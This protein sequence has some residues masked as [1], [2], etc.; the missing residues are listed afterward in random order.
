MSGGT[1]PVSPGG[2]GEPDPSW[3]DQEA[4]APP[5]GPPE[6]GAA[7][8]SPAPVNDPFAPAAPAPQQPQPSVPPVP[9]VQQI[10]PVRPIQPVQ[11]P[12]HPPPTQPGQPPQQPPQPPQQ[13]SW[14]QPAAPPPYGG[15][16]PY[17][18]PTQPVSSGYPPA[19]P[20]YAQAPAQPQYAQP[21]AQPQ[22]QPQQLPPE[23]S[24]R[25]KKGHPVRTTILTLLAMAVVFGLA[26]GASSLYRQFTA[27]PSCETVMVAPRDVLPKPGAVTVNVYN[28]TDTQG[29]AAK[30]A[31]GLRNQGF[32]VGQVSDDAPIDGV[33]E[34][35]YGTGGLAK[36]QLVGMYVP[37]A[38]LVETTR[39]GDAVSLVLGSGFTGLASAADAQAA[40]A[41]PS[42]SQSGAGCP[43]P[44]PAA[45][46]TGA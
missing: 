1:G 20:Q 13:S 24:P 21:P 8:A 44:T 43:S 30:T 29:L 38:T 5:A 15:A 9:P 31:D 7:P 14:T 39:S 2:S 33:G 22:P 45:S 27:G 35:R 40:L 4:S 25:R 42:P 17:G 19:Q 41:S 11:L 12:H 26:F 32:G 6:T 3:F 37:G 23:L 36:A 34:I 46:G 28:T 16:Q 18:S 10:P